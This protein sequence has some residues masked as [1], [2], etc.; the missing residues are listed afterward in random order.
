MAVKF[1]D[2]Q[3]IVIKGLIEICENF[4]DQIYHIMT[5]HGLDAPMK[6]EVDPNYTRICRI[7]EF[8]EICSNKGCGH[9][10]LVKGKDE[11]EFANVDR[12]SPEYE[13]LLAGSEALKRAG[14]VIQKESGFIPDDLPFCDS[15]DNPAVD[16]GVSLNGS[17][18]ES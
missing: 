14:R 3:M 16:S 2:E 8:G 13:C 17:V 6:I 9:I 10:R 1:S 12:N 5:N 11:Y 18:A 4:A 7:V 15:G